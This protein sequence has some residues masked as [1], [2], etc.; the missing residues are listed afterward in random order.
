MRSLPISTSWS[1]R[2]EASAAAAQSVF[3][4]PDGL[5]RIVHVPFGDVSGA[6]FIGLRTTDVLAHGWDLARATNQQ[7]DL[8]PELAEA[9]LE[10]SRQAL[11]PELRGPGGPFGPEQPCPDHASNDDRLAAFLGRAIP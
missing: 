3:A 4:A 10:W 8:D 9:M 2:D 11:R 6:V 1:R 5:T 7:T